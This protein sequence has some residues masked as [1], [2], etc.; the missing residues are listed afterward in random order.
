[1]DGALANNKQPVIQL[2]LEPRVQHVAELCLACLAHIFTWCSPSLC[3]SSRLL[4]VLFQYATLSI[5]T[6]VEVIDQA[7]LCNLSQV[8]LQGKDQ[9]CIELST[10]A[11]AALNEIIYKNY[12]PQDFNEYLVIMMKN[13]YQL[14]QNL[15]GDHGVLNA[16]NETYLE[17]VSEF[18]RLFL[19]IHLSRLEQTPHFPILEFLALIFKFTFQQSSIQGFSQCLEIW[20]GELCVIGQCCKY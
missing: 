4:N 8:L 19:S 10:K 5:K 2:P 1:M 7:V 16:M 11:M 15:V 9:S 3:V 18:L 14:L 6:Q 20:S 13:C 17:K 12:V